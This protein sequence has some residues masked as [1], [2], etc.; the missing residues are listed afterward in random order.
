MV[1]NQLN[2]LFVLANEFKEGDLSV[3][4]TRDDQIRRQARDALSA[5]SLRDIERADF[6][7]D[8]VSEA[9]QRALDPLLAGKGTS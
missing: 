9:L 3:G 7:E 4:G 8:Q 6:V 1:R 5:V 2:R